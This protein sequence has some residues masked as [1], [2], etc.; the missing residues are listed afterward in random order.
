MVKDIGIDL[1]T[2]NTLI[3]IKGQGIVLD[4]PSV[5]AVNQLTKEP[6]A[7]GKTANDMIGRTS[8]DIEIVF[9]L[10]GGVIAD[11]D[12]TMAMVDHFVKKL[13][14]TSVLTKPDMLICVPTSITDVERKAIINMAEQSG[15]KRVYVEDEPKVAAVGSG[16]NIFIPSGNM[17]IDLGGGTTDIAVISLGSTVVSKSIK[18]AGDQM[19][20]DI[21]RYVKENYELLIGDVMAE[22]VKKKL[23]RA[24]PDIEPASMRVSGRDLATGLPVTKTIKS[25]DIS[26]AIATTLD[27]IIATAAGV[28]EKTPPELSSDI[29]FKG[30]YLTGG[31]ALIKGIEGLFSEA[32]GVKVIVPENPLQSVAL[33]AGDLLEKLNSKTGFWTSIKRLFTSRQIFINPTGRENN[34]GAA[35]RVEGRSAS[36]PKSDSA[37]KQVG[38]NDH[39]YHTTDDKEKHEDLP[40]EDQLAVRE[41]QLPSNTSVKDTTEEVSDDTI[42]HAETGSDSS[43]QETENN[44]EETKESAT[45]KP[46]NSS[47]ENSEKLS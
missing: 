46:S 22:K 35:V 27:T 1:G 42:N 43:E 21:I 7:F 36:V 20:E 26:E 4:E 13:K 40:Q 16:L 32:L 37:T 15:A 17:I 34:Q 11:F 28:L 14:I 31:G 25:D 9:P 30:I 18:I 24:T 5:V 47:E 44:S 39:A 12:A 8:Q 45:E 19:D 6:I 2:V 3:N 33:G 41:E 38:K 29:M 10:K 23:A